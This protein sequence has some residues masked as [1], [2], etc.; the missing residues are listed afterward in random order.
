M[1]CD[2]AFYDWKVY[3]AEGARCLSCMG[4]SF[5]TSLVMFPMRFSAICNDCGVEA[6]CDLKGA[7]KKPPPKPYYPPISDY[8][9]PF[10]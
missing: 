3:G 9:W 6:T 2:A 4:Y 1:P 7:P 8:G 5:S 10:G